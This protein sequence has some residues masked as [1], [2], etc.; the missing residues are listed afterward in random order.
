MTKPPPEE[1]TGLLIA[2]GDGDK[3]ALDRVIP[4]VYQE[5][6]RLAR[7]QMRRERPGDTLQTT[8]LVNEAYLRL[9][10]Y[11]RI[12]PRDRAHFLA[13]AAQAMRRILIERA[14][15]RRAGKRGSNPQQVSLEDVSDVAGERAAD[16][17]AL[18][19]ALHA[20]AAIDPRKSQLVELRYFG[21]LTIEETAEVLGVSTPT[22]ERDWRTAK[23][24]LHREISTTKG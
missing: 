15:R 3:T 22:V 24:W 20:L 18:D 14:R 13:I 2:W 12:R 19:D 6:R 17:V 8:A 10:D 21:G 9:L 7:R 11:E 1:I 5:L 23:I 16:L 4:L